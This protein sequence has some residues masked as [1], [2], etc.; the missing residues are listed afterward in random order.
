MSRHDLVV[1]A[2]VRERS[3]GAE[4]QMVVNAGRR[5]AGEHLGPEVARCDQR[6]VAAIAVLI[7]PFG[8]VEAACPV[9]RYAAEQKR[10]VV[11]LSAEELVV[12]QRFR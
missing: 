5:C 4:E 9:A 10:I 11:V 2:P 3:V 7:G 12:V 8:I 6:H 1:A